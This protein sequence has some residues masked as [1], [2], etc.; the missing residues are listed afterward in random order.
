MHPVPVFK[1]CTA[2]FEDGMMTKID[3]MS[4]KNMIAAAFKNDGHTINPNSDIRFNMDIVFSGASQ[5]E[6]KETPIFKNCVVDYQEKKADMVVD[7]D[8][9]PLTSLTDIRREEHYQSLMAMQDRE[10]CEM[11]KAHFESH[12]TLPG[13]KAIKERVNNIIENQHLA[14]R[15]GASP[16]NGQYPLRLAEEEKEFLAH[17][18][19]ETRIR[20]LPVPS[21]A[22]VNPDKDLWRKPVCEFE[23][24]NAT[25][26]VS[27]VDVEL[28][29]SE[30]GDVYIVAEKPDGTHKTISTLYEKSLVNNPMNVDS[31]KAELQLADY[32]NGKMKNVVA[33]VVVDTDLMSGDVID[34]NNDMLAGLDQKSGLEQ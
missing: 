12:P 2:E 6:R 8:G 9:R 28:Q 25:V 11:I 14:E 7:A 30:S 4:T 17:K 23:K 5:R 33:K 15:M 3:E 10:M 1:G 34:L 29:K 32:S 26:Y 18:Y 21:M 31:C 19:A 13:E 22:G 24:N 16:V 20:E 27:R